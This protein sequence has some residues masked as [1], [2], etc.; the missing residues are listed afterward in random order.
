[1]AYPPRQ[2]FINAMF[3]YLDRGIPP[4][5]KRFYVLDMSPEG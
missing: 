5:W 4:C 3:E 1:M 2:W